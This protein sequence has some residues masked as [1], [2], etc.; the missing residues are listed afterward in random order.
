[1][2]A[3]QTSITVIDFEGTGS[4]KGYPDEPWQ[5][6][7]VQIRN[8]SVC[9]EST[10]ESLLRVGERPFNRYVPGRHAELRQEM[11]TAPSLQMLWPQLRPVLEGSLLAAHNAA[12]ETR[13][14]S[15]AF[16]LHPPG[17]WIDTLKLIRIACPEMKS[18]KLDDV[19]SQLELTDKLEKI[20]PGRSAHDALYDAVGCALLLETILSLPGWET[21]TIDALL[22]SRSHRFHARKRASQ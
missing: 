20:V 17:P 8:G 5:I 16:P 21:V 15:R 22:R 7:L 6:G 2:L 18:H 12:T 11:V 14:L 13:Y 19:L 4:V 3:S 9:A 10:F 1:M